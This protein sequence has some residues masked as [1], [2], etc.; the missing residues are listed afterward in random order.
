MYENLN[1]F[2]GLTIDCIT[3]WN[4]DLFSRS[5]TKK[6]YVTQSVNG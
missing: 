6:K 5:K 3:W 4:E 1:L 2:Q